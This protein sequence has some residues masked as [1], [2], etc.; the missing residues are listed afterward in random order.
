[1]RANQTKPNRPQ[2]LGTFGSQLHLKHTFIF[3]TSFLPHLPFLYF[4]VIFQRY[5]FRRHCSLINTTSQTTKSTPSC[6]TKDTTADNRVILKALL[7]QPTNNQA[8]T[9]KDHHQD[10]T[11]N[12]D[13][14]HK[15]NISNNHHHERAAEVEMDV[16]VPV[17][18]LCAVAVLPRRDVRLALTVLTAPRDAA[19]CRNTTIRTNRNPSALLRPH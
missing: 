16:L 13:L 10:N 12:K 14:P 17:S 7:N 5:A 11:I 2:R 8:D 19:R 1:V 6:R 18:Q 4:C 3:S 9:N 15:C